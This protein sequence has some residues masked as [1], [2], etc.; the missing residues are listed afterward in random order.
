MGS[1]ARCVQNP[2]VRR[3]LAWRHF[4][5]SDLARITY[6][7]DLA[8]WR[9]PAEL[10]HRACRVL[11]FYAAAHRSG[12]VGYVGSRASY[13]A[14]G[15]RIAKVTHEAASRSTVIR[16]VNELIAEGYIDRA[17]GRG[18]RVR[19][20]GPG[21]FIR[22]PIAVLTLTAKAIAIWTEKP[23]PAHLCPPVSN[24]NGYNSPRQDPGPKKGRDPSPETR[25]E[26]ASPIITA[27]LAEGENAESRSDASH[28]AAAPAAAVAEPLPRLV[29][30][31][32][33]L[34]GL[35]RPEV[36]AGQAACQRQRL[37]FTSST[38]PTSRPIAVAALLSTLARLTRSKRE[39]AAWI[40][41]AEAEIDGRSDAPPSGVR[42]DY[43]IARWPELHRN[44]RDRLARSEVLP[45]LRLPPRCSPR[46]RAASP[47]ASPPPAAR[48]P[49]RPEP[50]P[51]PPASPPG[52][53]AAIAEAEPDP[54]NPFA[55]ILARQ[56]ARLAAK[57]ETT[58]GS[59]ES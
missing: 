33:A 11:K 9:D 28:L 51:R 6:T 14:I 57:T 58:C 29:A 18:D 31:L 45:L 17:R 22:E 34:A 52:P 40:A 26:N 43:W 8:R 55:E 47:P 21:E 23:R 32:A 41:R 39:G 42:W 30:S 46:I 16:G 27:T 48:P 5:E 2:P 38:R 37:R 19:Q 12:E 25:I 10:S 36:G 24:C 15:A 20:I 49:V 50:P 1:T 59:S 53:P 4:T 54:L 7:I 13:S 44:E 3:D 56:L 35:E